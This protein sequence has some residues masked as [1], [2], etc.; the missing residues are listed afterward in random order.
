MAS[1][2]VKSQISSWTF[3][4]NDSAVI[5]QTSLLVDLEPETWNLKPGD[6][7]ESDGLSLSDLSKFADVANGILTE[8]DAQ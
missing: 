3:S 8:G 4:D 6:W 1:L 5:F 2:G 7:R